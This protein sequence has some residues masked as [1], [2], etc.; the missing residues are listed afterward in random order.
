MRGNLLSILTAEW[1]E[2]YIQERNNASG[3]VQ[4][5]R[6]CRVEIQW[7]FCDAVLTFTDVV[8]PDTQKSH[9]SD[10]L[11]SLRLSVASD[12]QLFVFDVTISAHGEGTMVETWKYPA[13][14]RDDMI[15]PQYGKRPR[16]L[17]MQEIGTL[18]TL[19]CH[20]VR[21]LLP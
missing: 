2:V 1:L 14:P 15:Y 9:D 17:N 5:R 11:C 19:H 8:Q 12:E 3:G 6:I 7:S 10:T 13:E 21:R 4:Y 20:R 18:E 16:T